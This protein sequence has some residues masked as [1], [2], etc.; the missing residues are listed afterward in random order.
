M[1]EADAIRAFG[2][3]YRG[4]GYVTSPASL[5]IDQPDLWSF[6]PSLAFAVD[7]CEL[8]P[9][10]V[11]KSRPSV[12]VFNSIL[13]FFVICHVGKRLFDAIFE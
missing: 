9:S 10:E 8:A 2:F 3:P 7:A 11:S 1:S 12:L 5:R 13:D 4:A 6:F